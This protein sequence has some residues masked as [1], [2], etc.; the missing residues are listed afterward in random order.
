MFFISSTAFSKST[1][2]L[3]TKIRSNSSKLQIKPVKSPTSLLKTGPQQ[4]QGLSKI[5]TNSRPGQDKT[6][7]FKNR[8]KRHYVK[9]KKKQR[10][11]LNKHSFLKGVIT[12]K[13]SKV[14]KRI[15]KFKQLRQFLKYRT[16]LISPITKNFTN[17]QL[18]F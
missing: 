12:K 8:H 2:K 14:F 16:R 17:R 4:E 15:D 1:K 11:N 18:T 10:K 7:V 5:V 9:M 13:L 6:P 3:T